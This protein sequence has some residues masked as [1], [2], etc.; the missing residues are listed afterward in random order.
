MHI[1]NVCTLTKVT[2]PTLLAMLI[3]MCLSFFAFAQ[4]LQHKKWGNKIY[5]YKDL[6]SGHF[7]T[8]WETFCTPT[9]WIFFPLWRI[10]FKMHTYISMKTRE[11][12]T[13]DYFLFLSSVIVIKFIALW[14]SSGSSYILFS[15]KQMDVLYLWS[16]YHL[17]SCIWY[18]LISSL[19][20]CY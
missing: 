19:P 20:N 15:L 14:L 10:F 6:T 4:N 11:H 3:M 13:K 2:K 17:H 5:H 1:N 7:L 8:F 9:F 18:I 16:S 12:L